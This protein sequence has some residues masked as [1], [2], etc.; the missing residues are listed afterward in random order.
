MI[1]KYT[2]LLL[3]LFSIASFSQNR[4]ITGK[5]TDAEGLTL[6]GVT[7]QWMGTNQGTVTD[8]NGS[9]KISGDKGKL[10]FSYVGYLAQEIEVKDQATIDVVMHESVGTLNEV[11]VIGYGTQKKKDLTTAVSTV[12][13]KDLADR[14]IFSAAQGLQGKAAGVEVV[15]PSGKPGS[16]MMVH[17]R[18][19]TSVEAGNEPLYVV[20]GVPTTDIRGLN[21]NDV[22]SMSVL[23]DASSAAIY[24]ARAANGVVNITTFRGKENTPVIKF[25][26]YVGLSW[27]RKT[28]EVLNT[29]E[30]RK[31]YKE[32]Y[33]N[34]TLDPTETDYTNWNDVIFGTGIS[35][36]YQLSASGG[37][38]KT[39]YYSSIGVLSDQ[40]IVAPAKFDRYSFRVNLDND[41]RPWLKIG[42]N[43]NFVY[44]KTK[45]TPDNASS[46]R[47]GVI[48]S[49]LNTPPFLNI[50]KKD[51][52]GQ[53]DPNPFQ[54]SWENPVAYMYGPKQ[55]VVDMRLL[56]NINA[57][58]AIIKDLNF[59][60]NFG[61][62]LNNHSWDYYLD[63]WKTSY[64]RD[65]HGISTTDK[66]SANS[67]L[68]E[69]TLDYSKTFGKH[70]IT[71]LA[72]TSIQRYKKNDSYIYGYNMPSDTL[73]T[74]P[75][76]A[77]NIDASG[78]IEEWALASF[79]GRATYDFS[80]KYYLTVS[81]R[82]DG[83]SKLA[84][85]WGT[86]PA[87]SAAWRISGEPFMKD[88]KVI[89]DLKIRGG[90]GR[91]GNQEGIPNYARYGLVAYTKVQTP[92]LVGPA[93]RMIT[94]GNP[95]LKWETTDQ[96]NIGIDLA[97]FNSR[98]VFNVDAYIK[99]TK[100][101]ILNVQLPA[102]APL[103]YIQTNAGKIENKGVEFN[104][105]TVN[106]AK[107]LRWDTDLNFSL[108]RNKVTELTYPGP[109]FFGATYSNN[110]YVS[111]VQVDQA[112]GTFYGYVAE[113]VD[114]KTGDM[115]Y[116]DVNGNGIFDPGDRT[117]I[118]C[119]QPKFTFGFTNTFS[120]RRFD[121]N[122]F[123]Q[124]SIG[125]DIYNATR[126]D[127]EGMF[128]HKNQSVAVLN[129][130]TPTNTSTDIPRVVTNGS[131]YNVKNSS[132]FIEDGSYVRLKSVT[133]SYKVFDKTSKWKNAP[134]LS[135]YV[136]GQN[137][138]TFTKYS[139]FDPEVNAYGNSATEMGI[140]YGTY[141]QAI[142]IITGINLEF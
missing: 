107:K 23:K 54:N 93:E 126:I 67:Y 55:Q 131:L 128:D 98:I 129:R 130:W 63:Y 61:I 134:K 17:V 39:R 123:F 51:G 65:K 103:P 79:F 40:G 5:V 49:A 72:G 106:I 38:E 80:S 89:N 120:Y 111:M 68:W 10:K 70:K 109:Y 121:L 114:P 27:L 73:V 97:M 66:Y 57:T 31:L 112:L 86:M 48:M 83:S 44:S 75:N 87:F 41:L 62:D 71:A 82:R 25:N 136:T 46:G 96:T 11:V 43:V 30:Y 13:E 7:V 42:S 24:G 15:S 116:K 90:W 4:V 2:I 117:V 105:H 125:N 16:D 35:Q 113:G 102:T 108:N 36:S 47:G 76:A 1:R 37:G 94:Y 64:G 140:D 88:V 8:A 135:V 22:A 18:G 85:P 53:Y 21:P 133:L 118:G 81:V 12:D 91:N 45:D 115:I 19:A 92:P 78:N 142:T 110:E 77:N 32:I 60:T 6:P 50:W 99:K 59:K 139:G 124:G 100:D 101:L 14:P 56:A 3:S 104:L 34:N 33:P 132:R 69:N 122:I 141:P 137:L 20:D 29:K 28:I 138:L 58:A 119:A 127:L 95:D 74:T 9:Y 26:T 52:S 84:N